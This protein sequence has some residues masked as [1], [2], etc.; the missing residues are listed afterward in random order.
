MANAFQT[1]AFFSTLR[2]I[3]KEKQ[4]QRS[5]KLR[6]GLQERGVAVQERGQKFA[7][8]QR[9]R[10]EEATKLKEERDRATSNIEATIAN[11]GRSLAQVSLESGKN[12]GELGFTKQFNEQIKALSASAE[13]LGLFS[14]AEIER[15]LQEAIDS[16][17]SGSLGRA[18]VGVRNVTDTR[19]NE[20]INE[21]EAQRQIVTG[22]ATRADFTI[23]PT[24][25]ETQTGFTPKV[26]T[27]EQQNIRNAA[28]QVKSIGRSLAS[29][30]A[31]LKFNPASASFVGGLAQFANNTANNLVNLVSQATQLG[32]TD[33]ETGQVLTQQNVDADISRLRKTLKGLAGPVAQF[34]SALIDSSYAKA[35]ILNGARPTDED[36][37]KA[38]NSLTG[39][40]NDPEIII[41]RFAAAN[42]ELV[43]VVRDRAQLAGL[44]LGGFFD[45]V[46]QAGDGPQVGGG[47]AAIPVGG[48]AFQN[49]IEFIKQP[50]GSMKP[51]GN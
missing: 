24:R 12:S 35:L 37:I 23:A 18:S 42:A 26:G 19:T 10:K 50:D 20:I 40:S 39:G 48:R 41:E 4:E 8:G 16:E 15:K 14:K 31:A 32:F 2:G 11:A 33:K 36:V 3:E 21:A 25:Q 13:R 27:A 5:Q 46:P 7:E 44:D 38:Y 17:I 49:G 45:D 47:V 9:I 43:Q 1:S 51:K 22:Q 28:V 34:N 29:A 30:E 6:L